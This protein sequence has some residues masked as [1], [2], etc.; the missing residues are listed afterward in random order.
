M[1]KKREMVKAI[2]DQFAHTLGMWKQTIKNVPANEWRKGKIDYLTPA[3]HFCHVVVAVDFFTGNARP[4]EYDWR[5]FAKG[6][7]LKVCPED[8]ASKQLALK[9]IDEIGKIVKKRF[10]KLNDSDLYGK[11]KQCPWAGKI[12]AGRLMFLLRHT[13]HHLGELNSELRYR[14]IKRASWG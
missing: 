2:E 5:R 1:Q 7:W 14:K 6:D 10:A 4:E 13:Q 8:L 11:E 3:R 9:Q 12:L